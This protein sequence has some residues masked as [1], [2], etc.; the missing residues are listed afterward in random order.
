MWN[1][2]SKRDLSR[3]LIEGDKFKVLQMSLEIIQGGKINVAL[4]QIFQHSYEC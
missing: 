2:N 4:G 3:H 1:L